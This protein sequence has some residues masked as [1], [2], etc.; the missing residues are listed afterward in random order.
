MFRNLKLAN[1]INILTILV[2]TIAII[3]A[4][5]IVGNIIYNTSIENAEKYAKRDALVH[6][7]N[8][9]HKIGH[10]SQ[11]FNDLNEYILSLREMNA[12]TRES[13][14]ELYQTFLEN[15]T[16]VLNVYSV[17]EADAFDGQDFAYKNETFHDHTGRFIPW[18]SRN[19][20][21]ISYE[22]ILDYNDRD[23]EWYF[24][25]KETKQPIMFDPYIYPISGEEVLI[26]SFITPILDEKGDFLGVFGFDY[27]M[28]FFQNMIVENRPVSGSS[29]LLTSDGSYIVHGSDSEQVG[30][31]FKKS[32]LLFSDPNELQEI[33][34]YDHSLY[35]DAEVLRVFQPITVEGFDNYWFYES[36]VK[37]EYILQSFY[38]VIY[39]IVAIATVTLIILIIVISLGIKN[40]LKPLSQMTNL[41]E[42]ISKGDFNVSIPKD[43]F[44]SDEIGKLALASNVMAEN[45]R[46]MMDNLEA[47]N[48][49]IIAQNIEITEQ[50]EKQEVLLKELN[51]AKQKAEAANQAKTDFLATM[52]HE[53]RTPLNG[54]IGMTELLEETS[55]NEEQK[56]YVSTFKKAGN[57]LLI[58][59]N[60]ILDFSKVESGYLELENIDFSVEDTV[61]R[62]TELLALRAHSKNLELITHISPDVPKYLKGDPDRLRQVLINLIGNAI[63]FTEQG[64]IIVRVERASQTD[65]RLLF[66]IIDTG[67][68]IPKVKQEKIFEKFTQVDSSTTRKYGGTGLGLAISKK[69]VD[70]MG[71]EIGVESEEGNGSTF[72]FYVP[73]HEGSATNDPSLSL[74]RTEGAE[75]APKFPG[76]TSQASLKILLVE[77]NEDNQLL[78]KSFLKKTNHQV[79]LAEN[80]QGAVNIYKNE[81][82]DLVLMDIQMPIL[83]GYEA[84]KT[85]RQW[86]EEMQRESTPIIALT[87]HAFEGDREKCLKAGCDDY[88]SKPIKKQ[89]L[90]D[91]ITKYSS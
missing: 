41:I 85:I 73:L 57:N 4:V 46:D 86:E 58:L 66:S 53:I 16:E 38:Y 1:R 68:G 2:L 37:K 12:I 71:G 21:E 80:G 14:I 39:W 32:E 43:K 91:F 61:E 52:S 10:S 5:F 76:G 50:Q 89:T 78:F 19:N 62:T 77:D 7:E 54:I 35:M 70:A 79:I 67:V 13:V 28:E 31:F 90:L 88:L 87:A 24:L 30:Q 29:N 11:S 6:A 23:A 69:I 83:D 34:F 44:H 81:D 65:Q 51:E 45:L 55:L 82:F 60:D 64:E 42:K 74:R 36:N 63:K 27:S 9:S 3:V 84:T 17:W 72:Y 8:I 49:E 25:P 15:H 59:I 20:D 26:T 75:A 48:E 40:S 33:L 18:W 47:Q 56:K 22:Q